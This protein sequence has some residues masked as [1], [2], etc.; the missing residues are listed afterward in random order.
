MKKNALLFPW[1]KVRHTLSRKL[2]YLQAHT[3]IEQWKTYPF[4]DDCTRSRPSTQT[5]THTRARSIKTLTRCRWL[6]RLLRQAWENVDSSW[7]LHGWIYDSRRIRF[8]NA[9]FTV[10]SLYQAFVFS[11]DRLVKSACVRCMRVFMQRWITF[12]ARQ[13]AVFHE[14]ISIS[15]HNT[16]E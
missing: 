8:W 2:F 16:D 4:L 7:K 14:E 1:T 5:G 11:F 15:M 10:P 3:Q 13:I 9:Y 12:T 6:Q